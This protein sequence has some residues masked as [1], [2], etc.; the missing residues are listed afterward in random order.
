[1]GLEYAIARQLTFK[2]EYL[3]TDLGA[4]DAPN[5]YLDATFGGPFPAAGDDMRT[6]TTFS[7]LRVGLNYKFDSFALSGY[8]AE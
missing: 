2:V 8:R 5:T 1:M 7:T 6:S 3:Y 4:L